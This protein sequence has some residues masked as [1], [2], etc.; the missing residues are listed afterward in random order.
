MSRLIRFQAMA[1]RMC[2]GYL[3][4]SYALW[5]VSVV[6]C[7]CLSPVH[8]AD[9]TPEVFYRALAPY[10]RWF[11]HPRYGRVWQPNGITRAWRPYTE[12]RWIRTLAYGWY[13]QAAQVWGWVPF[14]YGR[15]QQ[16]A[17]LGWLWIPGRVWSPAWVAWQ[18]SDGNFSWSSG[19]KA[20]AL[21]DCFYA[22]APLP[23]EI[24]WRPNLGLAYKF[25][26]L[27]SIPAAQWNIV[28]PSAFKQPNLATSI[29]PVYRN[30]QL[31][32]QLSNGFSAPIYSDRHIFNP[33]VPLSS[34]QIVEPSQ[35]IIPSVYA[36]EQLITQVL[37]DAWGQRQTFKPE[38][39]AMDDA[40]ALREFELAKALMRTANLSINSKVLPAVASN[41]FTE[42]SPAPVT[43]T[44]PDSSR[45]APES[46]LLQRFEREL[47]PYGRW[48]MHQLH[49]RVWQPFGITANWRP[50]SQGRWLN[51]SEYGWYW[52]AEEV[53]G[54]AP[55]HYGR[56]LMDASLGWLWVPGTVWA[57]AW[58]SWQYND[59]Y[60]AWAPLP[61]PQDWQPNWGVQQSMDSYA[62]IPV[63][64]WLVLPSAYLAQAQLGRY[65]LPS[66]LN[67]TYLQHNLQQIKLGQEH[68][69]IVNPGIPLAKLERDV[70]QRLAT[71]SL[72]AADMLQAESLPKQSPPIAASNTDAGLKQ[73]TAPIPVQADPLIAAQAKQ[74]A[75]QTMADTAALKQAQL[76]AELAAQQRELEIQQQ[77]EQQAL[78]QQ[79]EQE[80]QQQ[81]AEQER[82]L[83]WQALQAQ[84]QQRLLLEQQMQLQQ[85]AIE[86]RQ[87]PLSV[88]VLQQQ[89]L[90]RQQVKPPAVQ[91]QTDIEEHKRIL[92]QQ[93]QIE[94]L[95]R[96]ADTH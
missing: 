56:W 59:T 74:Q 14:H 73:D 86:Q 96:Q 11:E 42:D 3:R 10:G 83:Q 60:T 25:K 71:V 77:A 89:E 15:W 68:E 22:W 76:E 82:Q 57:P 34:W 55:Y 28:P 31:L 36:V 6:F 52:Q 44:L 94:V 54:W 72:H 81:L 85:R 66:E 70:Q 29:L 46:E 30:A 61:P 90:Q 33:G 17:L 20:C 41:P 18:Y 43:A 37:Y 88:P 8:A 78:A 69:R 1:R 75:L 38:L 48:F 27:A 35:A 95:T 62:P 58:V 65:I 19:V 32:H 79:R 93:R 63:T 53:W 91:A 80:A 87:Q 23:P 92:E 50:Y 67:S 45:V 49:G 84:E 24:Y 13:W 64:A 16:D 51:T 7:C 47:K 12:G 2:Y 9:V 40:E 21:T 39:Y 26:S 5:A 4:R